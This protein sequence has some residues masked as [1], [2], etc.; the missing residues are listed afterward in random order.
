MA[1]NNSQKYDVQLNTSNRP[2]PHGGIRFIGR[3]VDYT[4]ISPLR[5]GTMR[6][7]GGGVLPVWVARFKAQDCTEPTDNPQILLPKVMQYYTL[8]TGTEERGETL[9]T[10]AHDFATK[11]AASVSVDG[12]VGS[13]FQFKASADYKHCMAVTQSGSR[14]LGFSQAYYED[15]E[16]ELDDDFA[17]TVDVDPD[18]VE[19]V[20]GLPATVTTEKHRVKYKQFIKDYGTHYIRSAV[21]GGRVYRLSAKD[22]SAKSNEASTEQSA[23]ATAKVSGGLGSLNA[24]GSVSAEDREKNSQ[25]QSVFNSTSTWYGGKPEEDFFAWVKTVSADLQP[26]TLRLRRLSSLFGQKGFKTLPEIKTKGR[27]LDAAI[28]RYILLQALPRTDQSQLANKSVLLECQGS[29]SSPTGWKGIAMG[30]R[31]LNSNATLNAEHGSSVRDKRVWQLI[32]AE[33]K[34]EFYLKSGDKY[35][36][37]DNGTLKL[38]GT[39]QTRTAWQFIPIDGRP[40]EYYLRSRYGVDKDDAN[41]DWWIVIGN[42]ATLA[43]GNKNNLR[44]R[45]AWKLVEPPK[46]EAKPAKPKTMGEA[47]GIVG[48]LS[49]AGLVRSYPVF[50]DFGGGYPL[51]GPPGGLLGSA[52]S[53]FT[54]IVPPKLPGAGR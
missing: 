17:E 32:Q 16:I 2:S 45:V 3:L 42:H 19:A 8:A 34:D 43:L 21:F 33:A 50:G 12:S 10:S 48:G 23:K 49:Y 30:I 7:A 22:A 35:L 14:V 38:N 54:G 9:L 4:R 24:S 27:L 1:D 51:S 5:P 53:L 46:A 6:R 37:R 40:E 25:G 28:D 20:K 39:D 18:L 36:H 26:L 11:F 41:I 13:F 15:D 31:R 52:H 44:T 47:L 29:D